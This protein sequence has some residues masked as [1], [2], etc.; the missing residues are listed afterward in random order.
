MYPPSSDP[1]WSKPVE[2]LLA[3]L[4]STR[5]G[6]SEQEAT[7]RL[8][9]Q[10]ADVIASESRTSVWRV[11]LSARDCFVIQAVLTGES[12][13]AEKSTGA[14]PIGA[15]L[16]DRSNVVFM[17]TSVR[18]GTAAMLV[19]RTGGDTAFGNIATP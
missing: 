13:P 7:S 5:E 10:G 16:P 11:L 3:E 17:G 9:T 2:L 15:A 4:G 8:A 6:L 19:V 14:A 18:S 12:A 1:Y